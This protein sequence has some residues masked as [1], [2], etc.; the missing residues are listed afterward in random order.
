MQ[1]MQS[2]YYHVS[3]IE[4]IC[5][6]MA[7]DGLCLWYE[8]RTPH[9]EYHVSFL[10][11]INLDNSIWHAINMRINRVENTPDNLEIHS[12][13]AR[14]IKNV[15]VIFQIYMFIETFRIWNYYFRFL[16]SFG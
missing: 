11:I 15:W 12:Q 2:Y 1:F 14:H 5:K 13:Y 9:T 8:H 4:D 16:F 6:T 7:A 10:C 3:Q